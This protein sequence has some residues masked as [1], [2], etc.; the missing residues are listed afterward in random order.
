[1][2]ERAGAANML[3]Q[4]VGKTAALAIARRLA[5]DKE[6]AVQLAAARVLSHAG[7][8]DGA[9][10]VFAA[11]LTG[12]HAVQAA[13]DLAELGD[14][15]GTTAL[16]TFVRDSARTPDQRAEAATAHRIAHR[17]TP[18]LIAALADPNGLVRVEA[19]AVIAE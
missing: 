18:G 4:A 17:V 10:R 16:S 19:A 13:A 12:D 7:D 9:A 3:V 1:W 14:T 15:R 2:S 6:I 5:G 11:A 8:R